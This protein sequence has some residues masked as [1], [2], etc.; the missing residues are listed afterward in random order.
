MLAEIARD[1]DIG[2]FLLLSRGEAKD[3]GRARQ[4]ILANAMEAVIGAMYLDSGYEK[5]HE[6]IK[7]NILVRL[8][9]IIKSGSFIDPKSQLQE[10]VQ[11]KSGITPTYKV[12]SEQGPDHKKTFTMGVY[13]EQNKVGSGTGPSKQEAE[14]AAAEDALK[15]EEWK[16][17]V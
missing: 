7:L 16:K 17:F 14:L 9:Q 6:F 11:D 12:L 5:T 1:L 13:V 4:V 2:D 3:Q 15:N 8:P 10:L